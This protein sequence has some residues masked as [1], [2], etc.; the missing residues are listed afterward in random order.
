MIGSLRHILLAL[1]YLL[2]PITTSCA[3]AND[4][5]IPSYVLMSL[6]LVG[7]DQVVPSTGVLVGA[8]N[9]VLL[10][11]DYVTAPGRVYVLDGG[12]DVTKHGRPVT[13]LKQDKVSGLAMV[14][15]EGMKRKPGRLRGN[16]VSGE[17]ARF[18]AYAPAELWA[19]GK[20]SIIRKTRVV[21]RKVGSQMVH[22]LR[23]AIPNLPGVG[24]DACGSLLFVSIPVGVPS[25]DE[26]RQ[27]MLLWKDNLLPLVQQNHTPVQGCPES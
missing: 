3:L 12:F 4:A 26:D 25:M 15:V 13:V 27:A 8:P 16:L 7:G 6:R 1:A 18:I 20:R 10:P 19:G 17:N 11:L 9:I 23:D 2:S 21:R 5:E 24:V 14:K 22:V